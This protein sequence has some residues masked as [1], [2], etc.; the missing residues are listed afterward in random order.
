MLARTM[1][2]FT[3]LTILLMVFG[4]IIGLFLGG[5]P[6]TFMLFGLIF[7]AIINFASYEWSDRFVL[8]ST[9]TKLINESDN[10]QLYSIVKRVA[11][12]A[13]IPMP[14]VGIVDSQQPNAFATGKGPKKAIVVAT[15]GILRVLTPSELEAVI[16][17][18]ISHVTHRDVL[19]ASI[20]A[21]IA[22]TISY[23]GQMVLWNTFFFGGSGSRSR[24]QDSGAFILMII[25][26]ILVPIGAMLVQLG[27]SRSRESYAD[28]AGARLTEKPQ[29][30]INAL[31]KIS[32]RGAST[33]WNQR[34]APG[35]STASLWIVNPLKGSSWT[36][37]FSTHPSLEHRIERISKVA[38]DMGIMVS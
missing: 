8:W 20:A 34:N 22:G 15:T 38:Q 14:R 26:A 18:E 10:P 37:M 13:N 4:F 32:N 5:D 3:A 21:T 9:H 33:Q 29:E 7:A 19:V 1:A 12:K 17:H 6:L 27:I 35:P 2:M 31:R 28:E 11:E 30:L 25:A 23:L 36:E 24:N 16:G